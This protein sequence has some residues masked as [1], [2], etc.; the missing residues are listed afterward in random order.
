[1]GEALGKVFDLAAKDGESM[2]E[3]TARV[4]ET[5]NRCRRKATVDFPKEARG[6]IALHC[7]GVDF[8]ASIAGLSQ[9]ICVDMCCHVPDMLVFNMTVHNMCATVLACTHSNSLYSVLG[10]GYPHMVTKVI[11]RSAKAQALPVE[12]RS[13]THTVN[14]R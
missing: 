1:M 13:S 12:E 9:H 2:K 11:S 6:R 7:T 5:F 8:S 3:W 4:L 10:L 14:L